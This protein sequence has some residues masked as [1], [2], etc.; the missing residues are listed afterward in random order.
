MTAMPSVKPRRRRFQGV[1]VS[2]GSMTKTVR[3][4]VERTL[5]HPRVKKQVRRTKAFLVHDG[6]GEAKVGDR[7]VIEETRP[8]SAR[9]H[10]R[11]LY[12]ESAAM[13]TKG[14]R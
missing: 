12:G 5:W 13:S 3:V 9:K 2:A 6:R 1:V 4:A 11:I 10:F 8:L 7:V 14:Q